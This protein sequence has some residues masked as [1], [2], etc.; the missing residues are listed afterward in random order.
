MKSLFIIFVMANI[1]LAADPIRVMLL[2]GESAGTYHAWKQVTPVLQKQLEETGIFKV[3]VV[4]AP[5]AGVNAMPFNPD[6]SKYAVVVWNYDAPDDRWT[7]DL[8]TSFENYVRKGGGVVIVHASDNAFPQWTAFN[9]M[10]GVGGWRGRNEKS[11]PF[12]YFKDGKLV[13]D[14]TAGA[15]GSHGQRLPFQVAVRE[16]H[17][18]TAGLPKLWMHAGDELYAR[19]R[20]PGKNMTVLATA[21]SDP[22]NAGSGH[23]EPMLIVTRFGEGR[24]F[25]TAFGHDIPALNSVDFIVTFQRGTEW[26]ATGKVTQKVPADFPTATAVSVRQ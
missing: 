22:A 4:T 2:D 6:F 15:A 23:D 9:E 12:W 20:G 17:P 3:D 14:T 1:A 18:V 24:V 11:G 13:S 21:F 10:T 16:D 26:A 7:A 5:G 25:H 8:K 19:M